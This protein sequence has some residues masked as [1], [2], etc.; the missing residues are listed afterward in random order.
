MVE[1]SEQA[2]V[3]V[4][5]SRFQPIT[6]TYLLQDAFKQNSSP[7]I[8][9]SSLLFKTAEFSLD[10]CSSRTTEKEAGKKLTTR[11][12]LRQELF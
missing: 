12:Y 6:P 5:V 10:P 8:W 7:W 3:W 2:A 1:V 11:C 4:F 9:V